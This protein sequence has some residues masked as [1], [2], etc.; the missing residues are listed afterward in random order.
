MQIGAFQWN[1]LQYTV[2]YWRPLTL[3][4]PFTVLV[5][6]I[7]MDLVAVL[8]A[9]ISKQIGNNSQETQTNNQVKYPR[10]IYISH[11]TETLC[12]YYIC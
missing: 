1:L 12:M 9:T 7:Y 2:I 10:R 5:V 11:P 6:P 8:I 3:V 4:Y